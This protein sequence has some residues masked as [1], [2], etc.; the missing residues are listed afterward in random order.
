[1]RITFEK[2]V[3][4]VRGNTSHNEESR[5]EI[6]DREILQILVASNHEIKRLYDRHRKLEREIENFSRYT[7][8][9][10]SAALRLS[11]LKKEKLKNKET[12]ISKMNVALQ[13][14]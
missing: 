8:Y 1:M 11:A 10:G 6:H 4:V 5:M 2:G 7:G 13:A 12:L 9:S 14:A 3:V